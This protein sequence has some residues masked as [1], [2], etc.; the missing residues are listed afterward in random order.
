LLV[1]RVAPHA[2][3]ATAAGIS[4]RERDDASMSQIVHRV[5]GADAIRRIATGA[6]AKRAASPTDHSY[7]LGSRIS[8]C[9]HVARSR[10]QQMASLE[11]Y[12]EKNCNM[13]QHEDAAERTRNAT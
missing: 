13:T 12:M 4:D 9:I 10:R 7:K 8:C 5:A 3:G 1:R 11:D 2:R 6:K